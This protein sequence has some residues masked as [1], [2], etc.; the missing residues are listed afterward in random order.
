MI[1]ITRK[2][3]FCAGH[4]VCGH[5]TKCANLHGHNYTAYF[6]C[7]A[8]ELDDIGRVVDFS[9]IKDTMKGWID[10]NWDHRMVMWHGDPLVDP[11]VSM[12]QNP[13]LMAVNPTAENM[14]V[15]LLEIAND[16]LT[17]HGVA[18]S[19]VTLWETPNCYAEAC[20]G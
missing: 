7:F 13:Y 4:R 8:P 18:C 11:V 1:T 15:L 2:I 9:V 20:R 19:K 6:E 17:P 5:E 16:L 12:D 10:A 3:E 14:A